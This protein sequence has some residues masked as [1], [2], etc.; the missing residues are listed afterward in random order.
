MAAVSEQYLQSLPDIYRDILAAFPEL[1]PT[2]KAGYGLAYQTLYEAL[3]SRYSMGD[4]VQACQ[5]MEAGGAVEIKHQ[6]F[7]HPTDQGEQIIEGLTG[8]KAPSSHLP[9]F[10]ELPKQ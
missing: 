4:I 8:K 5:Q 9:A 6:I 1:E 7:V 2:R 10:P 3:R